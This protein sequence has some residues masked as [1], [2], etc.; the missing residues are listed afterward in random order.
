MARRPFDGDKQAV[1]DLA[2]DVRAGI[3]LFVDTV[4]GNNGRTG[5]TWEKSLATVEEACN[6]LT[7]TS[8]KFYSPQ[9][10][11]GAGNATIY[12]KGD[13]REQFLAPLGVHGVRIMGAASGRPRHSTDGGVV[14]NGN[15]V[16]W[17][18]SSTAENK[19]LIELR[20]QGW[21]FHNICMIPESGYSAVKLHC[22][23]SATYPD[24]SHALFNNVRFIGGG[25]RVGYGIE[26]YGGAARLGVFDCDFVNLE[27]AYN[28]TNV[29]IRSPQD[30][31]W[32]GNTFKQNKHDIV[33]NFYGSRI[34][35]NYFHTPY[36]GTTHPN[37]VN[38]AYTSN[39]GAATRKNMVI[40]NIFADAA[41]DVTI[42]KGYKPGTGDIW[43]N[44]VTDTAAD[45][46]T[47]P[48]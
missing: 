36:D 15:G 48:A 24:A 39:A 37:T 45:I 21:E 1:L 42:A 17:R 9:A 3:T 4:N 26:D 29:S 5:L 19:P 10:L 14:T 12:V 46:V 6:R 25:T 33:G 35:G 44:K 7:S 34:E 43:R 27:F 40:N 16:S 11:F 47:V 2:V 28:P 31:V 30:Q 8:A 38:L 20:Q 22:E 41:A 13:I 32:K 23:E 18:Q